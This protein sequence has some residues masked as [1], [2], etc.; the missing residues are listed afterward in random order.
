MHGG[1]SVFIYMQNVAFPETTKLNVGTIRIVGR[2]KA[3]YSRIV[4]FHAAN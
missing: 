4:I 2:I 1:S 3:N